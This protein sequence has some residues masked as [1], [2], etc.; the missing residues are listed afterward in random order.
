MHDAAE[1]YGRRERDALVVGNGVDVVN[2]SAAEV[3]VTKKLRNN[4]VFMI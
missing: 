1:L 3:G 2:V 4:F